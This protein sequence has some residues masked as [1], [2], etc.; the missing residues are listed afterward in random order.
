MLFLNRTISP[1]IFKKITQQNYMLRLK[2][3]YLVAIFLLSTLSFANAQIIEIGKCYTIDGYE[4]QN[5]WNDKDYQNSNTLHYKF[6]K[7]PK[8]N[9]MRGN[10]YWNTHDMQVLLFEEDEIKY[11]QDLGY[12][13]INKHSKHVLS[14]V[15][16]NGT[17]TRL[18]V[19]SEDLIDF[20]YKKINILKKLKKNYPSK[21]TTGRNGDQ[22]NFDSLLKRVSNT[23]MIDKYKIETYVDGLIIGRDISELNYTNGSAIKINL[24]TMKYV[25]FFFDD[26]VKRPYD[27]QCN[28]N[29]KNVVIKENKVNKKSNSTIKKLLKKLY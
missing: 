25:W 11:Y 8:R 24:N 29:Y 6:L 23:T 9:K 10:T 12:N 15:F 13:Q 28:E 1:K 5:T 7:E 20:Q 19:W 26:I 3:S 21:W 14:I 16:N 4:T 27:K 2:K 22:G 17:V 18:L